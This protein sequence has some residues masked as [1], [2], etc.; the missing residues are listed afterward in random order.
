MEVLGETED[1]DIFYSNVVQDFIEFNWDAYA[2]HTH[3]LGAF[4]HFV[5]TIFLLIYVN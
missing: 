1:T 4:I 5:Y 3:M 2:K